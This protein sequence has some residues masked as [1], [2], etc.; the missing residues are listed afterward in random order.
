MY[1]SEEDILGLAVAATSSQYFMVGVRK[2]VGS[3]EPHTGEKAVLELRENRGASCIKCDEC[4]NFISHP[5]QKWVLFAPN[6][7]Q[8]VNPVLA[9]PSC[10]SNKQLPASQAFLQKADLALLLSLD[11]VTVLIILPISAITHLLLK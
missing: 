8:N 2:P 3:Y 5:L 9:M 7:S 4:T 10:C 1:N 11:L 6:L